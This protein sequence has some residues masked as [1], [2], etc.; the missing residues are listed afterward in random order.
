MP[1]RKFILLMVASLVLALT[2]VACG[3]D[4]ISEKQVFYD[5]VGAEDRADLEARK[6]ANGC[7]RGGLDL[8][9][10]K[11]ASLVRPLEE[12]YRNEVLSKY[13]VSQE[14]WRAIAAKGIN[15][16]WDFPELQTC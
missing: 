3:G 12:C 10:E 15:E 8:D 14:Q 2:L 16:H 4:N 9:V 1:N 7:T 13:G 5:V 6:Q 11:Y